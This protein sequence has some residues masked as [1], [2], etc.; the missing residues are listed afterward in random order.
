MKKLTEKERLD[1]AAEMESALQNDTALLNRG[2]K[3]IASIKAQIALLRDMNIPMF[4]PAGEASPNPTALFSIDPAHNFTGITED[5]SREKNESLLDFLQESTGYH[6]DEVQQEIALAIASAMEND[7]ATRN[8]PDL[9]EAWR[10]CPSLERFAIAVVS[11][12]VTGEPE[13]LVQP[14][15]TKAH[16]H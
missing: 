9:V 14:Y 12:F 13:H 16:L 15:G 10:E 8:F 6:L 11:A 7:P 4:V 5:D 2:G 1:Y 3:E